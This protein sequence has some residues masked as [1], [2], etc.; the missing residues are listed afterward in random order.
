MRLRPGWLLLLPMLASVIALTSCGEGKRATTTPPARATAPSITSSTAPAPKIQEML[1]PKTDPVV[2][3]LAD[4]ERA[5]EAGRANYSAGHMEA[6]K[7]DFDHAV[8]L[9]LQ[10]PVPVK[11]YDR[12]QQEFDR[13]VEGVHEL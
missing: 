6:A 8:D 2:Q 9:L 1:K 13:V 7:A 10:S 3:V 11:S 5:Y 12:L 4:V